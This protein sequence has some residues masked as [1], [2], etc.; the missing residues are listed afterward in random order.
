MIRK[1]NTYVIYRGDDMKKIRV[2]PEKCIA[3]GKCYLNYPNTFDCSDDGIA[4]VKKNCTIADI[5]ASLP[6]MYE[7]PTRAIVLDEHFEI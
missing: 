2:I 5:S 3:C 4:F 1:R 7:C 6:A